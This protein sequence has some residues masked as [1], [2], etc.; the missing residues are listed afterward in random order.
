MKPVEWAGDSLDCVRGF[1]PRVRR[2]VGQQLGLVQAGKSPADWK[3]MPSIGP[4]VNEIR[5]HIGGAYRLVYVAKFAEAVYVLHAFQ[6]KSSKTA[7]NDVDLAR[8]RF[9]RLIR[10]RR[11]RWLED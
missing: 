11:T 3:P 9:R 7:K 6:K 2:A 5:V 8:A 10:D 4:G 1:D